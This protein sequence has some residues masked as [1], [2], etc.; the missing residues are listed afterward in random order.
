MITFFTCPKPFTND[1]I[2]T[3]Q[4]NAL[5]SWILLKPTPEIILLGKEAGIA[6]IAAEFNVH[7]TENIKYNKYGTPYLNSVFETGQILAQNEIVCYLNSDIILLQDL[8]NAVKRVYQLRKRFLIVGQRWNLDVSH[9]INFTAPNWAQ[10]LR[11][12]VRKKGLLQRDGID[13][14]IFPSELLGRLPPFIL[15]R[16]GWDYW[17]TWR[18]RSINI[19]VIDITPTVTVIH[20]NH[21]YSHLIRRRKGSEAI[22][23]LPEAIRNQKLA[24]GWLYYYS[25]RQATY[26]LTPQGF[27]RYR[28]FHPFT[29]R[30][31][32]I[33]IRL[34]YRKVYPHFRRLWRKNLRRSQRLWERILWSFPRGLRNKVKKK[35]IKF[36]F[37]PTLITAINQKLE[38]YLWL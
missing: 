13:F 2:R 4:I 14:F 28:Y 33:F 6:E 7:H 10:K 24:G 25:V 29:E 23:K 35:R 19:P 37:P 9:P 20:Q 8:M 5:R 11:L 15:G 32:I 21:D 36:K 31:M 27:G 30:F 17:P 3:I 1:H 12:D 16:I 18:A 38:S 34:I 26:R 22:W